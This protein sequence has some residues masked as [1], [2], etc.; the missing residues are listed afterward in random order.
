MTVLFIFNKFQINSL[1][2]HYCKINNMSNWFYV[3][4]TKSGAFHRKAEV[5]NLHTIPQKYFIYS[6]NLICFSKVKP[7]LKTA[8]ELFLCKNTEI[9]HV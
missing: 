3:R 7:V 2:Q 4:K 8:R 9:I 5:L 6:F 1:L